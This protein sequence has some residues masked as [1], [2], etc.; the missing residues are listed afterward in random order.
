MALLVSAKSSDV[1]A[2]RA[3]GD[4]SATF[5]QLLLARLEFC[6]SNQAEAL[7]MGT[8]QALDDLIAANEAFCL[9]C[10]D[11][12]GAVSACAEPPRLRELAT[13][14]F[15]GLY[16]HIGIHH[17]APAFYEFSTLFLQ[18]LSGSINRYA[19][20][21]LGMLDRRMP[22]VKLIAMGSAGR[23]EF[24]PF[25]PLQLMF[26][27]GEAGDAE[28]EALSQLGRLIH[29]G[30]EDCGLRVDGTVTPRNPEWRG[31]MSEW[32]QRLEHRLDRGRVNELIDLFRLADQSDLYHDEGFDPEFI[33]LCRS[34]LKEHRSTMAFQVTRIRNLSHGIGIMGGMRFEKKGPYRGQFALRDNALQP[35]SAAICV[36]ALLKGLETPSTPQRIR[37][38]LWRREL[39][40]DMAERL[41]QAWHA[42]HELRLTR[43]RDVQPAWTNEAALHLNV[44]EMHDSEQNLLRESLETV[45]AIQRHVGLTFSGMEE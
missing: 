1:L 38:I 9:R 34:L 33:V 17:S 19:H 14:F 43:E 36:L 20:T 11:L 12:L 31:S 30:F 26:V 35:L 29:E 15:A 40:V 42:L 16:E 39:N 44:E 5:R 18:A 21:T 4:F 13:A 3:S 45:G 32:R 25:C 6:R 41:L 10:S 2:W 22:S 7:L 24:S 27:H 8:G 37:E 23:Q 28:H